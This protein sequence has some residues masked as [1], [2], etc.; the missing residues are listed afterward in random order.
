MSD[1]IKYPSTP[2][3]PWSPG[4]GGDDSFLEGVAHFEGREVVVTEKLDGENTTMYRDHFHARS[5]DGRHHPSRDWVKALHGT[6]AGEIPVGWRICGENLYARHSI[7]YF[8]LS[9]YFYLFS[10]WDEE[11]RALGWDETMEWAEL[12]GLESAPVWFRGKFDEALLEELTPDTVRQEG[13]VVRVVDGF[14]YDDF[15]NSVAKWVR[16]GHV[17]TDQHWMFSGIVPNE[18]AG[19]DDD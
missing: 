14:E 10:V 5:L 12:L 15:S 19:K 3:L 8:D 11:N 13:H 9:S 1:P 18:L 16:E 4:G 17:Q 7:P 6:I 2:H